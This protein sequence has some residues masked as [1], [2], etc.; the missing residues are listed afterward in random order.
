MLFG[1]FSKTHYIPP[2][3][4]QNNLAE[5]QFIYIST[6][7]TSNVN[8]RIIPI[9][10]TVINGVVNNITP[11]IHTIAGTGNNTQLFIPKTSIGVINNKGYI[12]EAE[13]LVYVSVRVTAQRNVNSGVVSYAHAGGLVS[14]GN[15]ALGKVFRLGA[16]LNPLYD[17]SLLNFSSILA[18]ENNTTITISNIPNGTI[19]TD[20]TIVNGP[21][22]FNLN[23]NQS[24]VIA[25][26]NTYAI[27]NP[28]SSNSPSNSSKI[29]GALV[30][31]NK[32]VVVNAGS[33]G[34]SNSTALSYNNQTGIYSPTG[35]DVGFDQIVD[36]DK[37]GKEYIFVKGSGT[38]ELERVLLI[39]H[40]DNTQITINGSTTLT[41]LNKGEYVVLDGS[42]FINGNLFVSTS[43]K[44]FAYQSIGGSS[45]PANQN[46]F[47]VPP[48]NCA[49]PN[50]V[51]NI[52]Q[53]NS[54]GSIN[55][56]TGVLNIVTERNA[57]VT[58]NNT[59][60]TASAID[61]TGNSNYVR[62]TINGLS[63]N[64]AVKS[65]KQVYVSYFGN[66]GVATY[67]G[68]Y[69]GF[70]LKPEIVSDKITISQ[71][72]CIPNVI[73]KISTLSSYNQYQWFENDNEILG[74]TGSQYTPS[75]PGYY[76][77]RGAISGCPNTGFI[78]SDKIPVSTCPTNLD[79]DLG[80]DNIDIDNDNDGITNCT[81]SYGN[82]NINLSNPT[83]GN[84][85]IGSYSNS[86][87]GN[88]TNSITA[89]PIPFI[90]NTDGSFIS[91]V[92]A[93]KDNWVTYS[94][95][96]TQP[97]SLGIEYI[98]IA[99]PSDLLNATAEYIVKSD[100]DKTITVL[101]P[102]GQLDIDTNYDGIFE[103]NVTEFSSFEI[104]FRLNS[105][106]SL[107]A[108]SGDFKFLSYLTNTISFTHKNLSEDDSNKST[109]KFFAVCVPKDSDGDGIPDQLDIDSDN[110]GILDLIEAQI[111]TAKIYSGI[112]SNNNGLD[113]NFEPGF[114][115]IDTDNDGVPNYLDLDSDN[116][117]ILDFVETGNDFDLD[118]IKNYRDW[119]SDGDNC[120][121]VIE[122]GF[123][124]PNNDYF[125]GDIPLAINQKGIVTSAVG[126]TASLPN[127]LI[128]APIIINLQ[129][130][131]TEV[132][133]LGTTILSIDTNTID[134]YQWQLS[135]NN[136]TSWTDLTNNATYSGA[137]TNQLQ[138]AN[139]QMTLNA[140]QYSVFLNKNGNTCGLFTAVAMLTV[141]SLPIV[142]D[143]ELFQCDDD[144]DGFTLFNL[145]EAN[146]LISTND[147][148]ETF[149]FYTSQIGAE[150]A[151][152]GLLIPNPTNYN[153]NSQIIWARI[154]SNKG[155][156]RIAKIDIKVSTTNIPTGYMHN[157]PPKCDDFNGTFGSDI[158]GIAT[159][160]FSFVEADLISKLPP[161]NQPITIS[162]YRNLAD[163]L[164]ENNPIANPANYRNIG[165]P[166]TQN[167]YIRIDSDIDNECLGLGHHITL[168]VNPVPIAN[169]V[170][171]LVLCDDIADGND[172]NGMVQYFNLG[173]QSATILGSQSATN[174]DLTYHA[175]LTEANSGAN[176][177]SLIYTNTKR[178]KQ[179]IYVRIVNK[180]TGCINPHLTFDLIVNPLPI[181]KTPTP[182]PLCDDLNDGDHRNGIVQS[183][184]LNSKN[185][186]ILNGL[187]P[188]QFMVTYHLNLADADNGINSL[189]S[190]YTNSSP[191]NQTLFV[192]VTNNI[193]GCYNTKERLQLIVNPLPVINAI[194]DLELCDNPSDG[195]DA[196]GFVQ[197]FNL[198]SQT[199]TILGNQS[200][201]NFKVT[202]HRNQAD[203][204]AGNNSLVSP[205]TNEIRNQQTIFIR[206]L[207]RTTNCFIA[208]KSFDIVVKQKP[209]FEIDTKQI[210]CLNKLPLKLFIKSELENYNYSWFDPN[211]VLIASNTKSIDIT[212]G[213]TYTVVTSN[214]LGCSR[215]IAIEVKE[216]IIASISLDNITIV[217][218]SSNNSITINN[219]NQEIGIGDYEYSLDSD[220]G[221]YQEEP[222]FE[223][224]AA[225]VRTLFIRDKN[226]CGIAS[227][228]IPI[229]GNP[230]F[231][232]PNGDGYNDTWQILGIRLY[233]KSQ[234]YIF[235]RY[236][237]ALA[238]ISPTAIGWDGTHQGK[239]V[240]SGEY[241]F[242]AQ[243]DSGRVIK[244]HFSLI[245]R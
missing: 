107:P 150:T 85:D 59:P 189:A 25:L 20:G 13:D 181:I 156:Y 76:Q 241:W 3:S 88:T 123:S 53:I 207:N 35:R 198:E 1:Q 203:A 91:E 66:S 242:S 9:G 48:L 160:D 81:E 159:F 99:N 188:T 57:G 180:L 162:Y 11:Y 208:D 145:N 83:L 184:N 237:K 98:S 18:T 233:P 192:R 52:P 232:T 179:T 171:N 176:P 121:D 45:S 36:L 217:D 108:G 193:T 161:T 26:E 174:F 70:D 43:E 186:E 132:C 105:S 146:Q 175:F 134:S 182:L 165:Y 223:Q 58:I 139:A 211:G 101:N 195:N 94:M 125:L 75:A 213:G 90:G 194:P 153:A 157:L 86:F 100:I 136:G 127:Y 215:S 56:Y 62:Y 38:N 37:T 219:N 164:A 21:I 201:T 72:Q 113:N 120:S 206:I 42:Q 114:T 245:R 28:N 221:P 32:P 177:L 183:F 110:D 73:L 230:G 51:D 96:F 126:Y 155:C 69:S 118:G 243:L 216:S 137:T 92:P 46:M 112:D 122:A 14:K 116:D 39:A 210:I 130:N 27:N 30:E 218:N 60:I 226:N 117:G 24:Y 15:S 225:G 244:G 89:S 170:N 68:Y 104:R 31:A 173:S 77:V 102:S 167:I 41:P 23:K 64:I 131:N 212:K 67:G 12:I 61:I 196:N 93:G 152:V 143:A 235:D 17:T 129:P 239:Q 71:T 55:N 82:Q 10:G 44:V 222:F 29:I 84:L 147:L 54:I 65:D 4:A 240:D 228:E 119:D 97:I 220:F 202:Y 166:N 234:I 148:N 168:R 229:I 238:T 227:I 149:T 19:L 63:G 109:L 128:S 33:F 5:D 103:P 22:T 144:T 80:N 124:D 158:D 115:P 197:T 200:T 199:T 135:T 2:L 151:D 190:P 8:F 133:E 7:T 178:D 74:A 16:M 224:V 87:S 6:P 204:N 40:Y 163:A 142:K 236:G 141:N 205:F 106:I 95:N 78:F 138:I 172:A 154:V 185:T 187:S 47:F 34:G 169:P 191:N 214:T 50:S 111:N 79:Y 231:L 209:V 140:Y 49:T